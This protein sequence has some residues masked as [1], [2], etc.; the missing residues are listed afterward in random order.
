MWGVKFQSWYY[1]DVGSCSWAKI[2]RGI[3][4]WWFQIPKTPTLWNKGSIRGQ[5]PNFEV[6]ILSIKVTVSGLKFD[7][8]TIGDGLKSQKRLLWPSRPLVLRMIPYYYYPTTTTTTLLRPDAY[9][10]NFMIE[11][12]PRGKEIE[13]WSTTRSKDKGLNCGLGYMGSRSDPI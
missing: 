6:G 8:K 10:T 3:D 4:W 2:G 5:R 12:G 9:F 1:I 7:E 11:L 13:G